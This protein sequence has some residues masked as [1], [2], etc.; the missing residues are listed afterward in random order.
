MTICQGV[1]GKDFSVGWGV[2]LEL[3]GP[4]QLFSSMA[5]ILT[6]EFQT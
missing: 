5:L 6:V 1:C 3:E 4:Y 2:G